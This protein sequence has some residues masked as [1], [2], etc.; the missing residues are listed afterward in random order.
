MRKKEQNKRKKRKE[1]KKEK[2]RWQSERET[3]K[4]AQ[5]VKYFLLAF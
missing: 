4:N 3:E 1:N 2:K 5:I